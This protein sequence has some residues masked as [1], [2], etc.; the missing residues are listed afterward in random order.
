MRCR[1]LAV[2][3]S[4]VGTACSARRNDPFSWMARSMRKSWLQ[5]RGKR[6]YGMV[7]PPATS[8]LE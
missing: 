1:Q 5:A 8:T 7:V 2:G 4:L 6:P 3:A